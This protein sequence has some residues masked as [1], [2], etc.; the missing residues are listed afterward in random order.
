MATVAGLASAAMAAQRT[1]AIDGVHVGL[2]TF[3]LRGIRYP[4]LVEAVR[5]TGMGEIELFSVQVE[6]TAADVPDVQKWRDT[7]P[8]DYYGA[9]RTK[10]NQAGITIHTY[11]PRFSSGGGRG[12]R[13][14][15]PVQ[16]PPAP[17][18]TDAQIERIYTCARALGAESISGQIPLE[19]ARRLA[20][21]AARHR[22]LTA[23]E[24]V[25]P[26]ELVQVAALSPWMRVS[27]DI[28]NFARLGLDGLQ[29]VKD[30]YAHLLSVHLKDCK[31]QGASVPFGEGDA[32]MKEVLQFLARQHGAVRANIDCDYPGTGTSVAE[33]EKCLAYVR[34]C[35][36]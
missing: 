8:L 10:F 36:A 3:S 27:V 32:H 1:S 31:F 18:L 2:Q 29:F 28:G 22:T 13:G 20:P 30:H 4:E 26:A 34:A 21:F 17:P 5:Q 15:A 7:V 35:L 25:D 11:N 33:I 14:A 19:T 12:R 6:P 16:R 23:V 9:I 24:S